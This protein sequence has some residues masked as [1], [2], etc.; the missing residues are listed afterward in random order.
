MYVLSFYNLKMDKKFQ[1]LI[2]AILYS[3]FIFF[4]FTSNHDILQE[5]T[6]PTI[7]RLYRFALISFLKLCSFDAVLVYH[8]P[9]LKNASYQTLKILISDKNVFLSFTKQRK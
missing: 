4:S 3:T 7:Y 6:I 9:P 1:I 2:K 8:D 5:I